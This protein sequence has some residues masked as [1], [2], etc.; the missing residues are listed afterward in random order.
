MT[1]IRP[2]RHAMVDVERPALA[3]AIVDEGNRVHRSIDDTPEGS[4]V[5]KEWCGHSAA[6]DVIRFERTE[7][8]FLVPS[9]R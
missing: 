7:V 2:R 8:G 9:V 4:H 3:R 6:G 5:S 1:G